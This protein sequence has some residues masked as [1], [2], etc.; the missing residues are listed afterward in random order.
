MAA[1]LKVYGIAL[2]IGLIAATVA[3]GMPVFPYTPDSACYIEQARG[4]LLRGEFAS[5]L[6]DTFNPTVTYV[7]DPLFPPGYPV[8]IAALTLLSGVPAETV[9]WFLSL[10]AL[11][12]IPTVMVFSFRHIIGTRAALAIGLLVATTPAIMRWGNIAATDV[13]SLLLIM[14]CMGLALKAEL[15]LKRWTVL[16][17]LLGFAYLLRNANLAFILSLGG[18][19][20][21]QL[22]FESGQRRPKL[23]CTGALLASFTVVVVP[24]MLRNWL[25]FGK[26]QPYSMPPSTVGVIENSHA[27]LEAQLA[28]VILFTDAAAFFARTPLG[29]SVVLIGVLAL[30]AWVAKNWQTWPKT[31]KHTLI[32]CTLYCAFGAAVVIAARSKYQWGELIS[33]R[34]AL[35]YLFA[36]LT[37]LALILKYTPLPYK[38]GIGLSVLAA[39]FLVRLYFM[40]ELYNNNFYQANLYTAANYISQHK[41]TDPLCTQLNGRLG[42]SNYAFVYRVLCAVPI[43]HTFPI[44]HGD[45]FNDEAIQK[46][47]DLPI[48]TG[49]IVAMLPNHDI[50]KTSLP[51]SAK[52]LHQLN[53]QG[54]QVEEN[55]A[56]GFIIKR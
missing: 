30:C 32:I 56:M 7:P 23:I 22:V 17:L 34:H 39:L 43:R 19:I 33:E 36:L 24:W 54:W 42:I 48:T 47:L 10:S 50:D 38:R 9:A 3:Y 11:A 35:P 44:L 13:L 27:F 16:G 26:I 20:A 2:G 51:L 49:I 41:H 29:L 40:P 28:I 31:A 1:L 55:G 4:L 15:S 18:L 37:A 8:L 12:F 46:L 53:A 21:W 14:L 6:Y 52:H 45:T 5:G 25:V